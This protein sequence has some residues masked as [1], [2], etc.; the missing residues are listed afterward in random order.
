[1]ILWQPYPIKV[2][3]DNRSVPGWCAA[4]SGDTNITGPGRTSYDEVIRD[5][6]VLNTAQAFCPDKIR[7]FI[8]ALCNPECSDTTY[9]EI[10]CESIQ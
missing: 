6:R 8:S 10:K 1:M 5:C 2:W 9:E 4:I 3:D 7:E